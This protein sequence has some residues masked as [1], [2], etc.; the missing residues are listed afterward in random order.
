MLADPDAESGHAVTTTAARAFDLDGW[1]R[2]P[3]RV[4]EAHKQKRAAERG[5][6]G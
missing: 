1:E 5:R 6:F 3:Q 2:G 4:Q